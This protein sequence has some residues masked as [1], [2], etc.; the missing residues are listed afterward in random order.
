MKIFWSW[1]S[2]T[3]G[4]IG[5]HFVRTALL[6]AIAELKQPEDIDKPTTADNRESMHLDQDRQDRGSPD[7]ANLIFS[8]IEKA[9]VFVADVTP[10]ATI[11]AQNERPEKRNINPNVAIELGFALHALTDDEL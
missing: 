7:L 1:Q 11:P 4:S 6:E 9:A 10:V 2:D 5:R 8:K 3:P